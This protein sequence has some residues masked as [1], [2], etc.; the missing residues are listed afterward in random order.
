MR[1]ASGTS[2][3]LRSLPGGGG[4]VA[5]LGDRFQPDLVRGTG[6]YAVPLHLPRGP[7]ELQPRISL[8]YSTGAGNGPLG[9]GWQLDVVKIERR[10]DRGVPRYDD[11]DRFVLASAGLLVDVG[12]GRYRP[13]SDTL[14]W[15]IERVNQGW[16]VRTGD[17]GTML[18][19]TTAD[20]R[21]SEGGRD[22]AWYV[23]EERDAAGNTVEYSYRREGGQLYLEEI[24]Y[25]IFRVRW[26][27]EERPDVLRNG[28]AGFERVTR[29]RIARIEVHCERLAPTLM[30]TYSIEYA[31]AHNHSS[32]LA[33]IRL[34]AEQDGELA[35]QPRLTF[36]YSTL[37]L[38]RFTLDEAEAWIR[39]PS[40]DDPATQL[41]DL[42]SDG[43]PD[44]LQLEHGR[45]LRWI[46]AGQGRLEGPVELD[47]IPALLSLDRPNVAFADLD[48]DGRVE[49]FAVDQPLALAYR[50]DGAGG[51][52]DE[53]LVFERQPNV[54]LADPNTRLMDVDGDGVVD[55]IATERTH[56][57][58]H[59]HE[60]G[61]GFQEPIAVARVH[62]L[63]AFP[64]LDLDD[65]GVHLA[66]MTGDGLQDFVLVRSGFVS[67]WPYLGHGAWARRVVM[68]RSPV[69]PAGYREE[70]L[71]LVDLDGSGCASLVYSDA[72]R[73]LVWI[74]QCGVGFSEPVELPFGVGGSRRV[75]IADLYGD[76]RPA[77]VWSGSPS[78][79][80]KAG[81]F[82]LR[83]DPGTAPYLMTRI[84][85]G[86]GG[87]HEMHYSTSTAMRLR[88]RD[89]GRP[90]TGEMPI[91]VHVLERIRDVDR[92]QGRVSDRIIR[93]HDP[94]YDGPQR[95]FRGFTEV[96]V[97]SPGDHSTP[98][99]RQ[100]TT[101]FQGDPHV[102]DLVER[103]RQRSLAGAPVAVKTYEQRGDEWLLRAESNQTWATR[104]EHDD[105]VQQVYFPHVTRIE[106]IEHGTDDPARIDTTTYEDFDEHG[107]P[108]RRIRESHAEG[109]PEAAWI[110]SE[111]RFTYCTN[112][113]RW[114]VKLPARTEYL[115]GDG[116]PFSVQIH[117]YDGEPFVGLPEGQIEAGLVSRVVQAKLLHARLPADYLAGRDPTELGYQELGTGDRA[118]LYS[119]TFAVRRDAR[120]NIVEQRD[121]LGHA[122]RFEYDADGVYPL[123]SIDVRGR[124][125]ALSFEPRAGE[126]SLTTLP[127]GRVVRNQHDALG[128]LVATYDRSDASSPE[129]LTKTWL[130]DMSSVPASVTSI[131]PAEAG[132]TREELAAA[133]DLAALEGVSVS[134]VYYDGFGAEAMQ[135]T[136]APAEL[137]ESRRFVVSRR[138]RL[139]PRGLVHTAYPPAFTSDLSM[140]PVPAGPPGPDAI[141]QRYDHTGNVVVSAGPGDVRF[142]TVRDALHITH[143]HG[144]AAGE[145]DELEPAGPASRVERFDARARLVGIDEHTGDGTTITTNY[146]L[147]VDGRLLEIRSGTGDVM[148]RYTHGGTNEAIRIEHRDAGRRTYYHDAA[149]HLSE[150]VDEDGS[151]L[152]YHYDE[153]GRLVRIEH[154]PADD[155]ARV[156]LRE[157][158]H[159]QD[160]EQPSAGRFLDGRVALVRDG[161]HAIHYSYDRAG[162][163][164][165]EE[166][167]VEGV[168]LAVERDYDLQGRLLA[169]RY[170]DGHELRYELDDSGTVQRIPGVADRMVYEADGA[171]VGYRQAN[172][173][174]ISMPR[175][176]STRRLRT[177]GAERDGTTLRRL[178]YGYDAIGAITSIRDQ[179]PQGVLDQ[180]FS[181]DGLYRLRS[182]E[183]SDESAGMARTGNY[184]YDERGNLLQ[185]E[186][187]APQL[188]RYTDPAH[189]GRLTEVER[190]GEPITI[191]YDERG[192]MRAFGVL[193]SIEYDPLSRVTR[194]LKNDGTEI[195]AAYDYKDR[196]V[197]KEVV[198]DDVTTRVRY[199]TGLYEAH[200]GPDGA[201][202]IR[203]VFLANVLIASERVTD[204]GTAM[205]FYLADHLGTLLLATDETGAVVANQRYSPFGASW[206]D[207]G[208]LDRFL[209][210][211]A[212]GETGLIHLG[213][214]YYSPLI[215]RFISADWYVLENPREPMR[216][217]QGYNVYSYALNSPIVLKDPSGLFFFLAIGAVL[218]AVA[219]A[220]L[221]ATGAAFAVGFVAGLVYGLANGQGWGS[222]LTALETALTTTVGMWLGAV[223]GFLVG[224]PIGLFVGGAMGGFNGLVSGMTGIYDWSSWKGW[225]SF[226]S[227]STWG[228]VGTT[229]GNIV[230]VVNVFW[231]D[232][233]YRYDLSHRQNRHVYEGGMYLKEGFAFTQGNV[234]SNAGQSGAGINASFIANHEELHIWQSRIFGP[235]FQA[236]YIV[237]AVGGFIVGSIVWFTDTDEDWGSLVETAAY[238]DNP[239]EYWAYSNDNNWPP[240]GANPKLA[241]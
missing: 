136:T 10:S 144:P 232:S 130:I 183:V 191:S 200:E 39:P 225:L 190:A 184:A 44:V 3:A 56:H 7:N 102:A 6:N 152:L 51:F 73:T 135:V 2:S 16:R 77:L 236:T 187:T 111:E 224:G 131:A 66:D 80:R 145:L 15:D 186:E 182:F 94:V 168:A 100:V 164:V 139:N 50:G 140:V 11:G 49:L 90:W 188:M 76:G 85:N 150:R 189:P 156:T 35:E 211:P 155:S 170:P 226:L 19:G 158:H 29:L 179:M 231:P 12:D 13:D 21:E 75:L 123:R 220:A 210:R 146:E 118:G 196:R 233:N 192:R 148:V 218:A 176:P 58:L 193:T 27:Y 97:D 169:I 167:E 87:E 174:E 198:K 207:G 122:M 199:H 221:I 137:D 26:I 53:P 54:G 128:R 151:A 209:G 38:E 5:S 177:I 1:E 48:G 154:R 55:L 181:Y 47:G 194:F 217:P 101:M 241:Y 223:T 81:W 175:D 141:R 88:D 113:S 121:P 132:R 14:F 34:W 71:H 201:H 45:A 119:T 78:D 63:D 60:P 115:D 173:V 166:H 59:R 43:L 4:G 204:E 79:E 65:P 98:T 61:R 68:E 41:V 93:Y 202:A 86:M 64:D 20:S 185:M 219:V 239:F 134:R 96:T 142:R 163:I 153:L 203:H 32:L 195:R 240:G 143:Y 149:G 103:N 133:A 161:D 91:V 8:T 197:F 171:L 92:V 234:I 205:V 22:F 25:G 235:L 208:A 23:T 114:L 227:D 129:V 24:R 37:D 69:L 9:L 110:R 83:F 104:L 112:A 52:S 178:D 180:T 116:V 62:D 109:E 67:Y 36:D 95:H 70:N 84:D 99:T 18:L 160:P 31:Q 107:N 214:R 89:E 74:N 124:V 215:G 238:Y 42:D 165:R 222:L 28:R 229:L 108:G 40:V 30:R 17:G 127:D 57:L 46:N 157:L 72:D 159:D 147:G 162:K 125:T 237:W 172:G 212:D 105:L 106:T 206:S 138:V 117:Y 120:G 126:P 228:L 230:H 33:S 82:A 216:M 213:A